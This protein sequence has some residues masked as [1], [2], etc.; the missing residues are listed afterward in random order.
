MA[1]WKVSA[2]L[3]LCAMAVL[4]NPAAAQSPTFGQ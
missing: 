2:R 4:M 1:V 3:F